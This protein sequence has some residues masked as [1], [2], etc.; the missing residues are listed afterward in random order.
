[1]V[2][3]SESP[4]GALEEVGWIGGRGFSTPGVE[5]RLGDFKDAPTLVVGD[6]AGEELNGSEI[7][8]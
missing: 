1:M 6:G 4:S 5:D 3:L 8:V 7:G 2:E